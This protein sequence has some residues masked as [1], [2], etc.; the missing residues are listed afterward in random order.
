MLL[1]QVDYA[2][3]AMLICLS[4]QVQFLAKVQEIHVL[5]LNSLNDTMF[6]LAL[7]NQDVVQLCRL[8]RVCSINM[9]DL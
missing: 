4:F 2:T 5:L 8:Y 3:T 6:F 9:L 1:I 7:L